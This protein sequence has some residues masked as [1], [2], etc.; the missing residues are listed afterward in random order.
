M[1]NPSAESPW[2]TKFPRRQF[3]RVTRPVNTG[4]KRAAAKAANTSDPDVKMMEGAHDGECI[5]TLARNKGEKFPE[6]KPCATFAE[7]AD[8]IRQSPKRRGL[9][10]Q[11]GEDEKMRI[12]AEVGKWQ[13][14][15]AQ[16]DPEAMA[17]EL[18]E[19]IATLTTKH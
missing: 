17:K 5:A 2:R 7:A 15:W 3:T 13:K 12:I 4:G 8:F 19:N 16:K 11:K 14:P 10:M 9:I 18:S 6:I 1:A